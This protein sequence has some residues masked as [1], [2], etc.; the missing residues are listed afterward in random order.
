MRF[1]G[2]MAVIGLV[3]WAIVAWAL[4]QHW[5]GVSVVIDGHP[6]WS[7]PGDGVMGFG[8][9]AGVAFAIVLVMGVVLFAGGLAMLFGLG[10]ALFAILWAG[11]MLALPLLPLIL[12]VLWWRRRRRAHGHPP[13]DRPT[14]NATH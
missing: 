5:P 2:W 3:A 1:F 7:D 4:Y 6:V 11:G 10:I 14:D 12:L 8:A 13:A 9:A